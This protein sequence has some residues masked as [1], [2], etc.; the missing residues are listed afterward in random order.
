MDTSLNSI[1]SEATT[2]L[3]RA[4]CRFAS[5]I[6]SLRLPHSPVK[7]DV[8]FVTSDRR[9]SGSIPRFRRSPFG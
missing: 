4:R 3:V 7:R 8:P 5:A 2:R 1:K 6:A 9:I